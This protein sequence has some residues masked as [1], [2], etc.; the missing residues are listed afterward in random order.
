MMHGMQGP[1]CCGRIQWS[2]C[3]SLCAPPTITSRAFRG[4]SSACASPMAPHCL[5]WI[6]QILPH[7]R[8]YF[9]S[10]NVAIISWLL[11][12]NCSCGVW[13]FCKLP[14]ESIQPELVM[15]QNERCWHGIV[16]NASKDFT[17]LPEQDSQF[18]SFP[19]LEQLEEATEEALRDL[20]FGYR[21]RSL[22]SR[23]GYSCQG[24]H[25]HRACSYGIGEGNTDHPM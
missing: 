16:A 4:W 2:A 1:G 12:T 9:C 24:M 19:T 5:S 10:V 8:R 22:V 21:C 25:S 17:G 14:K 11:C 18:Y 13:G 3:S 23:S 20:G 7:C 6:R 15:M